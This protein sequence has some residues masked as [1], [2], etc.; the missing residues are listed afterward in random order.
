M[1]QYPWPI[2]DPDYQY[3]EGKIHGWIR[4]FAG[5]NRFT[6]ED[7]EDV[8]QE[9]W[10][11]V[12]E[13]R[14]SY[15]AGRASRRTYFSRIIDNRGNSLVEKRNAAKR[16]IRQVA[17]SLDDLVDPDDGDSEA[18]GANQ[19]SDEYQ[20][21]FYGRRASDSQRLELS[22]DLSALLRDLPVRLQLVGELLKDDETPAEIARLLKRNRSTIYDRI[23]QLQC[24]LQDAGYGPSENSTRHI[25]RR[26]GM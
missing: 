15:I 14:D 10:M 3:I 26:S 20:R 23:A 4:Q 11:H 25:D 9:L 21:N 6:K 2:N 12:F 24:R 1:P 13:K 22:I 19:S 18:R 17:Y 5:P 8:A 16:D 7:C